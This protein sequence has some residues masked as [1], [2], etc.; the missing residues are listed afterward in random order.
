MLESGCTLLLALIKPIASWQSCTP[1]DT[2]HYPPHR[3]IGQHPIR[4]IN[5][6]IHLP[7]CLHK[8]FYHLRELAMVVVLTVADH[9]SEFVMV[10]LKAIA[11][12]V[13]RYDTAFEWKLDYFFMSTETFLFLLH[14]H[15][16][17]P[18]LVQ[19]LL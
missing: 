3:R 19:Q 10:L 11:G 12:L 4:F 13:T 2:Y 15:S 7:I 17:Q 14:L 6:R 18:I 5:L 1:I 16:T 9:D 8:P